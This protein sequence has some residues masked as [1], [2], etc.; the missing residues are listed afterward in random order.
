MQITQMPAARALLFVAI[1]YMCGAVKAEQ[2]Y[3][4]SPKLQE[5][6][7]KNNVSK[8][9]NASTDSNLYKDTLTAIELIAKMRAEVQHR[10]KNVSDEDYQAGGWILCVM[11]WTPPK[12]P[13]DVE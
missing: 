12:L 13:P 8:K 6:A 11:P 10:E 1:L 4:L 9:L 5:L 3:T 7:I 2:T